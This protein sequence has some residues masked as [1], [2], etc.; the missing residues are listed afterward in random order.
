MLGVWLTFRTVNIE[1]FDVF[2][3]ASEF[4]A[5]VWLKQTNRLSLGSEVSQNDGC[6]LNIFLLKFF[7]F[8]INA[9][10]L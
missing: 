5:E 6:Y 1:E 2:L 10:F 7:N 8:K 4:P 3:L 9:W